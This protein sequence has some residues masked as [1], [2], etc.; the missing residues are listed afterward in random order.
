MDEKKITA[1]P[2]FAGPGTG[3]SGIQSVSGYKLQP[4]SPCIN[5]GFLI[6]NNGGRDY[7]GNKITDSK[8]DIGAFE[9]SK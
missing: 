4:G 6:L 8:P 5:A 9:F 3:G 1:D 2:K 7:W